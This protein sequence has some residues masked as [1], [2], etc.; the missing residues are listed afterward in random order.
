MK[1]T[2]VVVMTEPTIITFPLPDPGKPHTVVNVLE[3]LYSEYFM[4]NN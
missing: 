1:V 2:G 4:Q 3:K